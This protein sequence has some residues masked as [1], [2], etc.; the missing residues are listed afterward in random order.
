[1]TGVIREFAL[2]IH[3]R[4]AL[5]QQAGNFKV[6]NIFVCTDS[7]VQWSPSTEEKRNNQLDA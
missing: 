1:M 5:Q 4:V 2:R 6:L 3:I 7:I